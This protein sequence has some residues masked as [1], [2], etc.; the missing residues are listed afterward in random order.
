M[1]LPKLGDRARDKVTGVAGT[2]T[3]DCRRIGGGREF[4]VEGPPAKPGAEPLDIWLEK[5]RIEVDSLAAPLSGPAEPE[6]E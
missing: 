1:A 4:R 3:A 2:V 5:G 6:E